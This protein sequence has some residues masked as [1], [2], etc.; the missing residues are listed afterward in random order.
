MFTTRTAKHARSM[1]TLVLDLR[2]AS[3]ILILL[4]YTQSTFFR[5]KLQ[6]EV[7][8]GATGNC[9]G[10]K[11]YYTAESAAEPWMHGCRTSTSSQQSLSLPK[12]PSQWLWYS[13]L[14]DWDRAGG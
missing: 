11:R 13:L 6:G 1:E 10:R 14:G 3:H 12:V 4:A 7:S 5:C 8:K 9:G 2:T